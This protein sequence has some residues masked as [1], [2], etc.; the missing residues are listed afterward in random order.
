MTASVPW[1]SIICNTYNHEVFIEK[2]LEG[3]LSQDTIYP[4]EII[5]HDDASTDSTPEIIKRYQ[6]LYPDRIQTILQKENQWSKTNGSSI[7][8]NWCLK[9]AKGQYIAFC[10][11]DDYWHDSKKLQHQ[12]E[13]LEQFSEVS[14]CTGGFTKVFEDQS[15]EIHIPK[16]KGNQHT[17]GYFFDLND[18][19]YTWLTQPLTWVFRKNDFV[20]EDFMNFNSIRDIHRIHYLLRKGKGFFVTR[21]LG[22]YHIHQNG[23]HSGLTLEKRFLVDIALRKDI[24]RVWNDEIARYKIIEAI[25]NLS[26][27]Y[28]DRIQI[29]KGSFKIVEALYWCRDIESLTFIFKR[30][31]RTRL[32]S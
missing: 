27:F 16:I 32:F 15:S 13:I 7:A 11:G 2:T 29:L 30:V 22:V 9:K 8:T 5:I 20:P 10:E 31:I 26:N 4:F 23:V 6:E 25:M 28:F 21:S 3:F 24:F 19:R 18:T 14:L 17:Y 12:I 1:V